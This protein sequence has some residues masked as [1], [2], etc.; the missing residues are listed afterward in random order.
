MGHQVRCVLVEGKHFTDR[1]VTVIG[2]LTDKGN[3]PGDALPDDDPHP[4]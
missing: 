4:R 2:R 3:I 1:E